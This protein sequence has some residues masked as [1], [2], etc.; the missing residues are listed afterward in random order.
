LYGKIE[1][2][3]LRHSTRRSRHAAFKYGLKVVQ[4]E[5]D[6]RV[7]KD[8]VKLKCGATRKIR[9]SQTGLGQ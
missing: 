6:R 2:N 7:F 8:Y 4:P 3:L 5:I 9:T 1:I